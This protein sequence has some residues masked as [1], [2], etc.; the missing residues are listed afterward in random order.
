MASQ[1]TKIYPNSNAG[2]NRILQCWLPFRTRCLNQIRELGSFT[3]NELKLMIDCHNGMIFNPQFAST[4]F[5]SIQVQDSINLDGTD[6]T[7][8]ITKSDLIAKIELLL[9]IEAAFI[10][11][12]LTAFW[13]I[14]PNPDID[15]YIKKLTG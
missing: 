2:S 9:D 7:W 4:Q 12:W 13:L 14:K 5:L 15:E 1:I 11:E 3:A 10:I 8:E 6:K